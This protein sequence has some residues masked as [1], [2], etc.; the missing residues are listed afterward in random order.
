MMAHVY[1]LFTKTIWCMSIG[2]II[3]QLTKNHAIKINDDISQRQEE[4][5]SCFTPLKPRLRGTHLDTSL[6]QTVH[7]Q[8]YNYILY[9]C[10]C[11]KWTPR[12]TDMVPLVSMLTGF[13]CTSQIKFNNYN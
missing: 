1:N 9:Y 6:L 12:P 3:Y 10:T 5:K 13:N 2:M 4:V 7:L 8:A 11:L